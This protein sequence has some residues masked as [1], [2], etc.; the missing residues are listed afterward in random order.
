MVEEDKARYP[1]C[2][3]SVQ[4]SSSYRFINGAGTSETTRRVIRVCPDF[5]PKVRLPMW[6]PPPA[7]AHR[8]GH[9]T[10]HMVSGNLPLDRQERRRGGVEGR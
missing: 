9:P 1:Q 3:H 7:Q 8:N 4:S 6:L 5:A 2:N 10:T